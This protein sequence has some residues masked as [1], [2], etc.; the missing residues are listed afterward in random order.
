MTITLT[1]RQQAWLES[2]V[3]AGVVPSVEDAVRAAVADYMAIAG[4]DLAWAAPYV[5][6]A[7]EA[8]KNGEVIDGRVVLDRLRN[9]AGR[10]AA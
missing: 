9:R 5:E 7:R 8:M 6:A 3:E 2:Q 10:G 1:P 4:D